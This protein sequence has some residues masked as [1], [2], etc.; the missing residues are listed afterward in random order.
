M[1]N[2]LKCSIFFSSKEVN[3]GLNKCIIV[4]KPNVGKTAFLINFAE[5]LGVK[6]LEFNFQL[7]D[8]T[9][10]KKKYTYRT[11]LRELVDKTPHKTLS[12]QSVTVE[13]PMGKG[14]KK[15]QLVDTTGLID[16]IHDSE[17][18]RKAISQTISELLDSQIILHV[19]DGSA[20]K[21]KD[22]LSSPSEVDYQIAQLAHSKTG[23]VILVNKMDLPEAEEGL[24]IIKKEF[25]GNLIIPISAIHKRGFKEVKTF[26]AYNI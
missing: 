12:L 17:E 23:Y 5:Y 4:G 22:F 21:K 1:D 19:I 14:K 18:V 11:A 26:V 20:V 10:L 13:M 16:Y 3:A 7:P 15:I 25:S 8:G 24:K 6:K 2:M 9:K